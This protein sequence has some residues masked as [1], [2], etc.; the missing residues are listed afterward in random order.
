MDTPTADSTYKTSELQLAAFL[1]ARGKLILKLERAGRR[2][3]FVFQDIEGHCKEQEQEYWTGRGLVSA[4]AYAD[5]S[6][7]L[8]NWIFAEPSEAR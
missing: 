1:L 5:C 7:T 4:R 2:V 6:R 3:F 8:K